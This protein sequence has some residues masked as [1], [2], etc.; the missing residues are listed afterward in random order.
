MNNNQWQFIDNNGSFCWQNPKAIHQLYFPLCNEKG[1]MSSITP[2]LHGDIKQSQKHFLL[3]PVSIEDIHNSKAARN[4]W[5]F[6]DGSPW[7]VSGNSS[8]QHAEY[9][10]SKDQVERRI[11]AGLLWHKTYYKDMNKGLSAEVLSFVPKAV[12]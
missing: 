7:S 11:E 6:S 12:L 2:L 3:Q 9:L 1:L 10:Q 4:F 8:L 5:V